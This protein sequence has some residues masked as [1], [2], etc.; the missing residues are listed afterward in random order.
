MDFYGLKNCTRVSYTLFEIMISNLYCTINLFSLCKNT[1]SLTHYEIS[2]KI[3][4]VL[5]AS[6]KKIT[7]N[8]KI[9]DAKIYIHLLSDSQCVKLCI[10]F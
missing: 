5:Y 7:I 8:L 9:F 3:S 2:G 4:R 1:I 6:L 10:M